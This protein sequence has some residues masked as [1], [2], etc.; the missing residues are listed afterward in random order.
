MLLSSCAN[1]F[2]DVYG[3]VAEINFGEIVHVVSKFRLEDVVGNH[4]V[5]NFSSDF[6]TIVGEY[7]DV[8]LYVLPDFQNILRLVYFFKFVYNF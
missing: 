1:Q 6:N 8:I 7:D 2:V 5:E 3:F 4:C